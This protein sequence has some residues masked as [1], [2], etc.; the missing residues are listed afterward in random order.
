MAPV[1]AVPAVLIEAVL[2]GGCGAAG[3]EGG[4]AAGVGGLLERV[5]EGEQ[6][7]IGVGGSEER[8]ADGEAAEEAGGDGD[9][10]VAGD[11]GG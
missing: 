8:E 3:L 5:S 6:A 7:G 9:V 2:E 11:G 10:G 4:P 1:E